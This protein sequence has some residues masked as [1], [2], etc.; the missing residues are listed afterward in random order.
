MTPSVLDLDG[1]RGGTVTYEDGT[2]WQYVPGR[3]EQ[4]PYDPS[5]EEEARFDAE[6]RKLAVSD[7][8][9]M[10]EAER[11]HSADLAR[12]VMRQAETILKLTDRLAGESEDEDET[13]KKGT[14]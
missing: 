10:L 12:I 3:F 6:S 4:M 5:P 13:A 9:V 7:I 14:L 2:Q 11:R 1:L 8:H